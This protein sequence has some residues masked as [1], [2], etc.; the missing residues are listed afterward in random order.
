MNTSLSASTASCLGI[1][2]GGGLL[3]P[4][5]HAAQAADAAP[6]SAQAVQ[7][8]QA[9]CAKCHNLQIIMSSPRSYSDWKYTVQQMVDL[10][11]QGT[12]EQ[13]D[14]IMDY[15]HRNLTTIDVNLADVSEL[16]I[17][18]NVPESVAQN[19]VARRNTQRF[20]SLA[21]LKSVPGLDASTIDQKAKLISF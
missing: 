14:D 10:G 2:L 9:V 21:D 1:L 5:V 6:A 4:M 12:D 18:L 3:F 20:I 11:A 7:P 19:I 16:E 15:L 17:V 8:L 13:F